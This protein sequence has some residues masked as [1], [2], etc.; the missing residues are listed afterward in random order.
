MSEVGD[1]STEREKMLRGELYN[2][3]DPGLVAA[4]TRAKV[5]LRE[6]NSFHDE[7][8]DG[9]LRI[10]RGLL[11]AMGEGVW[12]EPPFFCDY[13][14]NI[15]LGDRVYFNTNC[16]LL[17]TAEVTIGNDVMFGP[18]V[19]VY[20]ASHP[21]DHTVR[22][23]GLELARPIV[24]GDDVWIGGSAILCPGVRIGARSVIGAGSVVTRDVPEGMLAAGNPCR[25]I[26]TL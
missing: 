23:A 14:D 21:L 25:V 2:G 9:R 12:V 17:D 18:N 11:A 1:V 20:T 15:R 10:L 22:R 4:R 16:V 13:G 5:A 7:D 6:F 26:R 24:I 3:F 19:Q 8:N